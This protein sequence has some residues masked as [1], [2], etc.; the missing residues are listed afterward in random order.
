LGRR[1]V[2]RLHNPLEKIKNSQKFKKI[3][4]KGKRYHYE[5]TLGE[6]GYAHTG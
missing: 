2:F 1:K 6:L 3:K 4:I 5:E